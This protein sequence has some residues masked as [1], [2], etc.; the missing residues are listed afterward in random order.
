MKTSTEK[1]LAGVRSVEELEELLCDAIPAL[2]LHGRDFSQRTLIAACKIS[3]SDP[4][5]WSKHPDVLDR[6]L[7]KGSR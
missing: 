4:Y 1:S 6:L 7:R 3:G 5:D 2:A